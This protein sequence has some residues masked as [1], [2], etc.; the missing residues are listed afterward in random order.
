MN[1]LLMKLVFFQF[2]R[3][4]VLYLMMELFV[5]MG[6]ITKGSYSQDKFAQDI[7]KSMKTCADGDELLLKKI[8]PKF[9][10]GCKRVTPSDT[11]VKGKKKP[12]QRHD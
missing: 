3:N 7:T 5:L 2:F 12:L 6:G 11:Y 1:I 10:P 9:P 4:F 8:L